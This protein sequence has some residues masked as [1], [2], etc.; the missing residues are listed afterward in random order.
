MGEPQGLTGRGEV[1]G[2]EGRAVVGKQ[3]FDAHTQTR[4][5]GHCV[6]E[7]LIMPAGLLLSGAKSWDRVSQ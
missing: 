7:E 4:V 2:A 1:L 5:V 3:P 6:L